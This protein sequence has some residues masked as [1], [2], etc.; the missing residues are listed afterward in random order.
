MSVLPVGISRVSDLMQANVLSQQID[1]TQ[2]Q[3]LQ[4]ENEM[5]TGQAVSTPS[6]NPAAAAIIMQLTQTLN[7]QQSYNDTINSVS[8]QLSQTDSS[9]G[10]LTTLLQQAETIASADVGSDVTQTQRTSDA[11]VVQSLYSQALSIANQQY[12][13]QYLFGGASADTQPFVESNGVVEFVGNAQTLQTSIDDGISI[14]SQTNGAQVFGALS[15]GVT[16]SANLSPD[17]S[18][19]TR[20][21]DL[22]GASNGG[23]Q[24]GS[25]TL[26]NGSL[27]QTVD[28]SSASSLGDVV[29]LINQAA[30][31]GITAS[32]TGQ[33]L[34]LTGAPTDNITLTG[35][36]AQELGISTLPSGAGAGT[37]VVGSSLNPKVTLLTPLA[38]LNDGAGIDN[39]GLTITNGQFSKT[40]TWS[41][42]GTVQDMLNAINGAG[43]G[44]VAQINS[45]GTGINVLNASQGTSLSIGEN[46]GNTAADLG[47]QTLSLSTP[48]SQLNNGQGVQTAGGATADFQITA[49]DGS[50]FQVS[51]SAATTVQDV[52]NEINAAT[53][54]KVTAS[55]ASTGSGI[56]LTDSSGGAGTLGVTELND[57]SAAG[58]LGLNVAASGNTLTGTDVGAPTSAGVFGN[59]QALMTALQSGNQ[60]DITAAGTAIETD[61]NRVIESQG[62]TGAVQKELT[63]QQSDLTSQNTATQSLLSQLQDVDMAK[64]ISQFQTLQTALEASLETAA[65]TLQISLLNF[66]A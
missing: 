53:G 56:V 9:L 35:A 32:I 1:G 66:I 65:N 37:P 22:G 15:S 42:T 18:A 57:S 6:D 52:I 12:N 51:V 61:V 49:R 47:L 41:P 19:S 29:N 30:V 59:L 64:A 34:T 10:N 54:G 43:L 55:L 25:I 4:V 24:L 23:L 21:S 17:L 58:D 46:G 16:G 60:R 8:A 63:N 26:G 27:T 31:G 28:L 14:S 2:A 3:L 36:T 7:R 45:A 44:L 20:I 5:S 13:G 62:K 33:G 38:S 40:I 48:L 11:S 39:S 50:T